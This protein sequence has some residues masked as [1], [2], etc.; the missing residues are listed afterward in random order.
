MYNKLPK[1]DPLTAEKN[2]RDYF[3]TQKYSNG[4]EKFTMVEDETGWEDWTW[5]IKYKSRRTLKWSAACSF[6]LGHEMPGWV[7][8]GTELQK[9]QGRYTP[10]KYKISQDGDK[11]KVEQLCPC[12]ETECEQHIFPSKVLLESSFPLAIHT[13]PD[14]NAEKKSTPLA[15]LF[16]KQ[17][18]MT[19]D[20]AQQFFN[21]FQLHWKVFITALKIKFWMI[22]KC[23][24]AF[25]ETPCAPCTQKTLATCCLC[26]DERVKRMLKKQH[27]SKNNKGLICSD[28]KHAEI[29]KCTFCKKETPLYH[30][31]VPLVNQDR[32]YSKKNYKELIRSKNAKIG[33]C[34]YC[35]ETC[36]YNVYARHFKRKHNDLKPH[37]AYSHELDL[38]LCDY[39]DYENYDETNV[40]EH[41]KIHLN[42][43]THPCK[44][45]CGESFRHHT[46]EIQHRR[47]VHGVEF[48]STRK[49]R[50]VG[51]K[52]ELEPPEPAAKALV[53]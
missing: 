3:L 22:C 24:E 47:K 7:L 40:K 14:R 33:I 36:A 41:S 1:Y 10:D 25:E 17:H 31:C 28:C 32:R 4:E 13:I 42:V 23:G 15:P 27:P 21:Q 34:P 50:R 26:G 8:E 19:F 43:L 6:A 37:G 9:L 20:Q 18:A 30:D 16:R 2:L 45:G 12:G 39:C 52:I 46:G 29:S 53:L 38:F 11:F 48:Q 44:L 49:R 5:T 35:R 51:N